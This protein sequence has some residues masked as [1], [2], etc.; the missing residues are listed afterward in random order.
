MFNKCFIINL[1]QQEQTG[2]DTRPRPPTP[3]PS[4][5]VQLAST[6]L[7][8]LP[9]KRWGVAGS[10]RVGAGTPFPLTRTFQT[11]L[12]VSVQTILPWLEALIEVTR[13]NDPRAFK[14]LH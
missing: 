13:G 7:G 10:L 2:T 14:A 4:A 12:C 11:S 9:G 3:H 5:K 8:R 1:Q 6:F